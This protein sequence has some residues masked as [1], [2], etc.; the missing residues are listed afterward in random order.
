MDFKRSSVR[1]APKEFTDYTVVIQCDGQNF[2]GHLGNI[3]EGGA[4][5]LLSAGQDKENDLSIDTIVTG[6]VTQ[7]SDNQEMSFSGK[8]AWSTIKPMSNQPTVAVGIQFD[9]ELILTSQLLA[10][11]MSIE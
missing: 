5:V 6:T 8:I 10:L 4:L 3:S 11:A 7:V 1:I 2:T 9:K